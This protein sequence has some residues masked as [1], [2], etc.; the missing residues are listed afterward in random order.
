MK[1]LLLSAIAVT[2][3]IMTAAA[4]TPEAE[5][6]FITSEAGRETEIVVSW[7]FAGSP[8]YNADHNIM[9]LRRHFS[10]EK[11][12]RGDIT[13]GFRMTFDKKEYKPETN[14]GYT[15]K[16][17]YMEGFQDVDDAWINLEIGF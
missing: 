13:D 14:D 9:T 6:S 5:F 2:A 1:K 10:I 16:V 3:S 4:V 11:Y 15:W 7:N 17:F 12:Q 8:S